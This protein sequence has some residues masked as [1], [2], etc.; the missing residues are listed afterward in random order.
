MKSQKAISLEPG[1]TAV[2]LIDMQPYFIDTDEKKDLIPK[3][4]S[5][6]NASHDIPVIVVEYDGKG[7]TEDQL[8]E[9]IRANHRN[10]HYTII[11]S[12]DDAFTEAGLSKV[13]K[14]VQAKSLVL[15]GI[16][17]CACV[18]RTAK[19]AVKKGYRIFISEDLIAGYCYRCDEEERRA[20]YREHSVYMENYRQVIDL[21]NGGCSG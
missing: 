17:A 15:M 12:S 7:R 19:S 9:V 13:L 3:Q 20:W 8:N 14:E 6:L 2:L 4:V 16:N 10:N 11:K 18:F 5:V 21:L 1:K